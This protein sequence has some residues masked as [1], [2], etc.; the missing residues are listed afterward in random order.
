[1][2]SASRQSG[3]RSK[4]TTPRR[5]RALLPSFTLVGE[6]GLDRRAGRLA[7]QRDVLRDVLEVASSVDVLLSL[8]SAG[9]SS[10]VVEHLEEVSVPGAILHWFTGDAAEVER[11][12]SSGAF[13]SV[14]SAM[15]DEQLHALRSIASYQRRI[16][17]SR[18]GVARDARATSNASKS[19]SRTSGVSLRSESAEGGTRT[20]VLSERRRTLSSAFPP[21]FWCRYLLRRPRPLKRDAPHEKPRSAALSG[22]AG[23]PSVEGTAG[24]TFG[25]QR[26]EHTD[27]RREIGVR[28]ASCGRHCAA[29]VRCFAMTPSACRWYSRVVSRH[30]P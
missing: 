28:A 5:F 15:R 23:S 9:A 7:R 22:R 16:S 13:F 10:L 3:P 4:R 27:A 26:L 17:R 11:A 24:R 21:L 18:R 14:N 29:L 25:K 1:M 30:R 8:H 12:A 19:V 2:R 20:C 6:V